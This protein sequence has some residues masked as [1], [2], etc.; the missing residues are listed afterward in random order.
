[1]RKWIERVVINQY[2]RLEVEESAAG[3]KAMLAPRR[4]SGY[5]RALS[6]CT[7]GR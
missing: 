6:Y 4:T 7:L 5:D 3:A 1:M 2:E